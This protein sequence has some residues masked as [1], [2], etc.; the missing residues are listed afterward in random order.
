MS[1]MT[2][3]EHL[4]LANF[5]ANLPEYE[6]HYGLF[7]L[8][9]ALA[10]DVFSAENLHGVALRLIDEIYEYDASNLKLVNLLIYLRAA[11]YVFAT[12]NLANPLPELKIWLRPY[13]KQGLAGDALFK[14]NALAPSTAAELMKLIT[15][16]ED[17]AYYLGTLK[18]LVERYTASRNNPEGPRALL[19]RSAADGFTGLLTVFYYAHS[20]DSARQILQN[21]KSWPETLNRFVMKNRE[22]LSGTSA[23]YQLADAA[24]ESYRFLQYP[25]QRGRVKRM[26]QRTL[27][28]TGM[29][30]PDSDLWLSAAESVQHGDPAHCDD[31]GVCDYKEKVAAAI[32]PS[33]HDCN[34]K[35]RI[36]AQNMT[37]AQMEKI[38]TR[39]IEVKDLFHWMLD[40]GHKPVSADY[41]DSIE[42]VLFDGYESYRKYAP[43]IHD[44]RTDNGGIYLEGDPAARGNQAR[45]VAHEASWLRPRFKVWNLEH[46]FIH[47]L[48]GRYNM[49]G[50]FGAS[51]AKPTVWWIEGV[52]EYLA[53]ANDNKDAIGK[54]QSNMTYRLSEIFQTRYSSNDW[55]TRAYHWGY[56]AT[57]FLFERHRRELESI[58]SRFRAGDYDGYE[59]Y[60]TYIGDRYEREFSEWV[61]N[62]DMTGKLAHSE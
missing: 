2:E 24:R 6:C 35:I 20:R 52:A 47:Y 32:L 1:Q 44:I 57:R 37:I 60:I 56:M 40:T 10:N 59:S 12:K 58:L 46:E 22:S 21:D 7:S 41:N 49:A 50:D 43:V 8:D 27:A 15:N 18:Q 9:G 30:G 42:L 36:V 3:Y 38:C 54:V 34:A 53:K 29:R 33:R 23:A 14:E 45:I 61:R 28:T 17:E 39:A 25:K 11:Y 26:V 5:V 19:H 31:Y 55:K 48:D 62:T 51:T 4:D 13:I 16:M